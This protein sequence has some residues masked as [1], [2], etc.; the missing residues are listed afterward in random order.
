MR[1]KRYGKEV[2]QDDDGNIFDADTSKKIAE[3]YCGGC[4]DGK[5]K[6]VKIVLTIAHMNHDT[7]DNRDEN[8]KALCQRCHNRYDM[9]NR[10][11]NRKA[12]KLL[13]QPELF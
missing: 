3:D 11:K 6:D 12:K 1:G 13:I 8:L 10:V 7:A 9:P 2:Y 4:F 5:Y